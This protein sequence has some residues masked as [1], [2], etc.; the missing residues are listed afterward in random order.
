LSSVRQG[1]GRR[2]RRGGTIG[3]TAETKEEQEG[4]ERKEGCGDK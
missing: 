4:K 1:Q 3:T 2:L